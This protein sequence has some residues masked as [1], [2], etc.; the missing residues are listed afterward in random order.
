M[1]DQRRKLWIVLADGE[2]ARAVVPT[3]HR[4]QF[5]T[6]WAFDSATA[7]EL[8]Q[9]LV[10]DRPGRLF[11]SARKPQT[12]RAGQG[13][14]GASVV[15]HAVTPHTDP[16]EEAK[17]HFL[18][19]VSE[20]LEEQARAGIF[21]DLVLIAPSHALH[22]LKQTLGQVAGGRVIATADKDLTQVPDHDLPAHLA[23][24]WHPPSAR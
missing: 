7:H 10:T 13:L 6:E 2:H 17:R 23:E 18:R 20:Q 5:R 16:K 4:V 3:D 12:G 24:W 11:S 8:S 9:D 14:T 1:A 15:R 22:D 19:S 21:E